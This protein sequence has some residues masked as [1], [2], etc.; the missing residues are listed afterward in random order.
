[1]FEDVLQTQGAKIETERR[2]GSF[3]QGGVV[4]A[5]EVLA[6]VDVHVGFGAFGVAHEDEF[7]FEDLFDLQARPVFG[8]IDQRRIEYPKLQ[9]AQQ[10][11][12]IADFHAQRMAGNPVAQYTGPT[13]HQRVAQAD[14]ATDVQDVVEPLGQG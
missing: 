11:L 13:E 10:V 8:L 3:R 2:L 4:L 9:L 14:F 5:P 12:A 7:F 6:P 1:V